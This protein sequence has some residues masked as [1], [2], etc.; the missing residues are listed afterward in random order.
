MSTFSPP[1]AVNGLTYPRTGKR[2]VPQ[3]FPRRLYEMLQS[4]DELRNTD[5]EHKSIITW[6]DSGRAFRIHNVSLFASQVL[7]KYFRTSKF[8]SFQRNLNLYGFSKVR[9]GPDTDM[10]A[11]PAF[12]RGQPQ[13]LSQLRK[14]NSTAAR[15]RLTAPGEDGRAMTKIIVPA[16][17]DVLSLSR[18]VSPSP[19]RAGGKGSAY[20][21]SSRDNSIYMPT[22]WLPPQAKAPSYPALSTTN[23][24]RPPNFNQPFDSGKLNLLAL[25][26]TSLAERD[27]KL[28]A[29]SPLKS[30]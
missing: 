2:G 28:N 13:S 25:A 24:V 27:A 22:V 3:Q 16:H 21:D 29:A 20:S 30:A 1:A 5:T 18:A 7:P 9:R 23:Q 4:E 12:V 8:S 15:K 26:M 11:H 6:S 17:T 14:C 19:P 10:Y